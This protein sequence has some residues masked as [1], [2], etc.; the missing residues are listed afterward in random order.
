[1]SFNT[2]SITNPLSRRFPLG[3]SVRMAPGGGEPSRRLPLGDIE[4]LADRAGGQEE[5]P[6]ASVHL[7]FPAERHQQLD[8]RVVILH[9]HWSSSFVSESGKLSL[10][11]MYTATSL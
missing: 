2:L 11:T 3:Y 4:Q 1:M 10:R 8:L 6:V 5:W 7:Q 9:R